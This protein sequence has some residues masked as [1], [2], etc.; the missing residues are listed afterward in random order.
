MAINL[1]NKIYNELK[2]R[3]FENSINS[4]TWSKHDEILKWANIAAKSNNL[5]Y[6]EEYSQK[7]R[8]NLLEEFYMKYS[9]DRRYIFLIHVPNKNVSPGGYSVFNNL[10]VALNYMGISAFAFNTIHDFNIKIEQYKPTIILASDHTESIN[11]INWSKLNEFKKNNKILIGLTA[12]AE[13]DV[14]D[15]PLK[16][17]LE[18]AKKN[19]IDFFYSFTSPEYTKTHSAFN[20]FNTYNFDIINFEFSANP[21]F[22][23]PISQKEKDI[24]FIF[25]AS[26]NSD[27]RTRYYSF[28]KKI[29]KNYDG[30]IDGPGWHKIKNYSSAETHK[31]LYSRSKIGLNLHIENSINYL[32][33]LNE[34]TYILAACGIPQ[35][36]DNAKLL[37]LRF[38]KDSMF[39]ANSTIEYFDLFQYM[40]KNDFECS[41]RAKN[42]FV[43]VYEKHTIFH[44]ITNLIYDLNNLM[45]K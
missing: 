32:S 16:L 8:H 41:Q 15:L 22:H 5:I 18:R 42:A 35:L 3:N 14:N 9:N 11:T 43:E 25:L 44:R 1:V 7:I 45:I 33:E 6:E 10:I 13:D 4:K 31:F 37:N 34:R 21:L 38:N 17:R 40:L 24:N 19:K 36:V 26:T 2:F 23:F 12:S 20:L 29:F 39:I 30:F 27:K 28:L